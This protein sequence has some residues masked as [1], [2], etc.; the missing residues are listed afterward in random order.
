MVSDL[1]TYQKVTIWD[2][3][4]ETNQPPWQS[5]KYFFTFTVSQ[6]NIN[7]QLTNAKLID[8]DLKEDDNL[9]IF[10]AIMITNHY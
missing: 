9:I 3:I 7:N 10:K 6:F 4:F 1:G 8:I 2:F 5:K